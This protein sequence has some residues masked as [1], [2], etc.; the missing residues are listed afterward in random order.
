MTTPDV[1]TVPMPGTGRR[2]TTTSSS[3]RYWP[4]ASPTENSNGVESS[5][6]ATR[7]TGSGSV[8]AETIGPGTD[9]LEGARVGVPPRS[10]ARPGGRGFRQGVRRGPF[11]GARMGTT[12]R[13]VVAAC[14]GSGAVR[15]AGPV[16]TSTTTPSDG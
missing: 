15:P 11:A 10:R 6:P 8:T 12:T 2:V 16:S 5:V 7:P 13:P 14:P 3:C 4:G 9:N 1:A